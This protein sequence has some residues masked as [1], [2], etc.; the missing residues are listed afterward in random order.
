MAMEFVN[1]WMYFGN[2]CYQ[3]SK[4]AFSPT[5][6]TAE[7]VFLG[8]QLNN[9]NATSDYSVIEVD[10]IPEIKLRRRIRIRANDG[11]WQVTYREA[12]PA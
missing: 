2:Q 1:A 3:L 11:S 12:N 4:D 6:C 8:I 7:R 5:F 9:L 10:A